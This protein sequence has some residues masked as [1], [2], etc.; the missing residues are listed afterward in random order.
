MIGVRPYVPADRA[1]V[2]SLAIGIPSWHDPHKMILTVQGWIT[3]SIEEHGKTTMVF[4]AEDEQGDRIGEASVSHS[5]HFTDEGQ[6]YIGELATSEAAEGCGGDFT[7][8]QACEQW[9]REQG[10][11][12]LSPPNRCRQ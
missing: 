2:L 1:F 12:I 9:A 5:T 7:L 11:R 3:G 6:A 10:Y 8:A 4:I